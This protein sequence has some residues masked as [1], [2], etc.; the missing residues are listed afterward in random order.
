MRRR[1]APCPL[2]GTVPTAVHHVILSCP[3]IRQLWTDLTP[4]L[5]LVHPDP[6]TEYEMVFGLEGLSPSVTLRNWLTF[7]LRQVATAYEYP[8]SLRPNGDHLTLIKSR[9]NQQI[10][11]EVLWKYRFYLHTQRLDTFRR[12]YQWG[13]HRLVD[14]TPDAVGVAVVF[15]V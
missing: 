13:V 7:K 4:F 8:A 5:L 12:L 6:V 2:C 11:K 10:Q 1:S 3:F 9:Y 14:V 15:D